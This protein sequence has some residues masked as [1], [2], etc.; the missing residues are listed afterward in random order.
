MAQWCT[1]VEES[2]MTAGAKPLT[3]HVTDRASGARLTLPAHDLRVFLDALVR[4]GYDGHA[5]LLETGLQDVRFENPDAR[6]P[7]TAVGQVLALAQQRRFTPNLALELARVIQVGA[8]PLIDYLVMTS[9]SVGAGVQQLARYL[10]ITGAPIELHV[11]DE[12]APVRIEMESAADPFVIEFEA[13][14]IV[15]RLRNEAEGPFAPGIS[16]AHGLDDP[17]AFGRAL[18]C[19]LAT[20]ASW[21]GLSVPAHMWRLKLRRRDPVLRRM[22]EG[23]A[24]DVAAAL[25]AHDGLAD[26][27]QRALVSRLSGGDIR[28]ASIGREFALSARSLQRRLASE[29]VSYQ[30][31]LEAARK[32]AAERYVTASELAIGEIAFL[33]GYSEP[34]PFHRAFK[35]WFGK[36]PEAVRKR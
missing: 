20:G 23:F 21:S 16:F 28:L 22:L 35:R 7:C 36:T 11:R 17:A 12:A 27:V 18:G 34:A 30:Q 13:A 32:A 9:D 31:L 19:P 15:L 3:R 10:R 29:G 8:W 26:E 25:P 1:S 24:D 5:L 4:L 6:V 2:A 33:L 14:L